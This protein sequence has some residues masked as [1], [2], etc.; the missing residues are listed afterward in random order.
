MS[1]LFEGKIITFCGRYVKFVPVTNHQIKSIDL[2]D[3][4][5]NGTALNFDFND[6]EALED[7]YDDK[8]SDTSLSLDDI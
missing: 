4:A 2:D 7:G 8:E 6:V 1:N 5:D 3:K